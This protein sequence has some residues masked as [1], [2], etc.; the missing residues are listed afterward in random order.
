MHRHQSEEFA[1]RPVLPPIEV[2]RS[3][4]VNARRWCAKEGRLGVIA[5]GAHADLI[6][7]RRRTAEKTCP[8]SPARRRHMPAILKAGRFV[9]DAL[10]A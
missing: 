4:T 8:C 6:V 3:A 9:K 10:A 5:P 7:R 1:A 2:I